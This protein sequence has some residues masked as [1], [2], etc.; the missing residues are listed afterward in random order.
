M[1]L[2]YTQVACRPRL[3]F[4]LNTFLVLAMMCA[5]ACGLVGVTGQ[6]VKECREEKVAAS[7]K[8]QW[9]VLAKL[10][11]FQCF[12]KWG[13]VEYEGHVVGLR[14]VAIPSLQDNDLR[15]D[16]AHLKGL[17]RLRGIQSLD[18]HGTQ[19]SDQGLADLSELDRVEELNLDETLVS[20]AGLN[21]LESVSGLRYLSLKG[22]QVTNQGVKKLK[23]S[24]SNCELVH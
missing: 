17:V 11:H 9:Q 23:Q 19:V 5:V 15:D 6:Q 4:S 20:D 10:Q 7:Q 8:E 2:S 21:R 3:R 22:T 1:D 24:L 12:P 13:T 16:L 14:L 18:L